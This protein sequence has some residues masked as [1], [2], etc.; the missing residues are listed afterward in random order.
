MVTRE[1]WI[2]VSYKT[3][4]EEKILVL[5]KVCYQD[6]WNRK[7]VFI[8]NNLDITAEEIAFIYRKRWGI[9]LLFKKM[10]QNFQLHYFYGE[11]ENAIWTQ[12]WCTLIAQLL[13]TVLQQKAK[14]KKAFSTVAT[15]VRIHLVSMLDVYELLPQPSL[16]V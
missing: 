16:Q 10:K 15:M 11:T 12:V 3:D 5:R 6:Q 4:K 13:L 7:Y 1:Q 9:E 2:E 14:V 8:S